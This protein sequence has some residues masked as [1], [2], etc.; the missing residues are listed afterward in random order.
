[1]YTPVSLCPL[2]C[3][4]AV[5]ADGLYTRIFVSRDPVMTR[6]SGNTELGGTTQTAVM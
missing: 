5:P 3:I 4:T 1:M 2:S 6:P